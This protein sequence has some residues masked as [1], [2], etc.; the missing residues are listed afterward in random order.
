MAKYYKLV[1]VGLHPPKMNVEGPGLLPVDVDMALNSND[2]AFFLDLLDKVY[3]AG[4]TRGRNEV[5]EPSPMDTQ[6]INPQHYKV[7][8]IECIDYLKAKL[9]AEELRGFLKGN[10]IKYLSRAEQKGHAEDYAKANWY[11][12]ML[13]GKDPRTT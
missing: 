8:G 4:L 1:Y 2:H 7:G 11:T 13:S 6:A 5:E 12:T 10:A 3:E 9:S